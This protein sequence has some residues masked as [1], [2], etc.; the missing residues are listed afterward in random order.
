MD[1]NFLFVVMEMNWFLWTSYEIPTFQKGPRCVQKHL[2][3]FP[4]LTLNL[5]FFGK[6]EKNC[7]ISPI[8]LNLGKST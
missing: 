3:E 7:H 6:I 8:F 2:Q 5:N 1:E 4:K